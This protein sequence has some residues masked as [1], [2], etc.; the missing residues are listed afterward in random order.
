M[1]CLEAYAGILDAAFVADDHLRRTSLYPWEC[2]VD[3]Q[4]HRLH[5]KRIPI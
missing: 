5:K 1:K 2:S 4:R 3:S